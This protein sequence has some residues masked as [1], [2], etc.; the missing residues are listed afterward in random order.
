[1]KYVELYCDAHGTGSMLR[2]KKLRATLLINLS[3]T[4]TDA[5]H[6]Y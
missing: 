3:R 1:M 6:C 4:H 5:A 2:E